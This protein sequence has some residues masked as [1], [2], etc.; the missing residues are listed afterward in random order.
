MLW[1]PRDCDDTLALVKE[2]TAQS[3]FHVGAVYKQNKYAMRVPVARIAE[4]KTLV[5]LESGDRSLI[6]GMPLEAEESDIE[7]LLQLIG[8]NAVV[9]P[10]RCVARGAA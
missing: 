7:E 6:R 2:W 10:A 3:P 1:P 4:A 9:A 5:G 8:W